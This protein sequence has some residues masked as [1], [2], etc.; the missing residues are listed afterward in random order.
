MFFATNIN[1]ATSVIIIF[2]FFM[3]ILMMAFTFINCSPQCIV[4]FSVVY[5]NGSYFIKDSLKRFVLK[6]NIVRLFFLHYTGEGK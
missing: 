2:L 6:Y 3:I 5:A 4:F 1:I